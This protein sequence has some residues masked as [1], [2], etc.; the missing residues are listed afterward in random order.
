M[1]ASRSWIR[2]SCAYRRILSRPGRYNERERPDLLLSAKLADLGDKSHVRFTLVVELLFDI[3]PLV[4]LLS[5]FQ[6][7]LL[8]VLLE[9][10]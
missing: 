7:L 9:V 1:R 4:V 8:T 5:Q 6:P 10:I 2:A 3:L